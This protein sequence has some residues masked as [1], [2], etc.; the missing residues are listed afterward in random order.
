MSTAGSLISHR[1]AQL[2]AQIESL[3]TTVL[4]DEASLQRD[5]IEVQETFSARSRKVKSERER[6]N[7]LIRERELLVASQ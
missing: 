2:D 3:E 6:L 1:L 5:K 4:R 7:L